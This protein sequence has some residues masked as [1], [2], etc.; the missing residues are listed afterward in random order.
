MF[1]NKMANTG[2][3]IIT[4]LLGSFLVRFYPISRF[5]IYL[6]TFFYLSKFYGENNLRMR[7][8]DA[9]FWVVNV[10]W[11]EYV[12]VETCFGIAVKI[13]SIKIFS[14]FFSDYFLLLCGWDDLFLK[15]HK[16]IY[17]ITKKN[18]SIFYLEFVY[19]G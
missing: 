15:I 18:L 2:K 9:L 17:I 8:R 19:K 1:S 14:K 5:E 4:W 13:R 12:M 6:L 10:P 11:R 3:L 16:W 7:I